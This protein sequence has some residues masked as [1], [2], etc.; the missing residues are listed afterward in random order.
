L[1]DAE[2][3]DEIAPHKANA[4]KPFGAL[5]QSGPI[6]K[7]RQQLKQTTW[8][9]AVN[10][11]GKKLQAKWLQ[12]LFCRNA[13]GVD[14]AIAGW[15]LACTNA[16]FA[17]VRLAPLGYLFH[18]DSLLYPWRGTSRRWGFFCLKQLRR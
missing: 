1:I 13:K 16:I 5:D 4:S 17:I 14:A 11:F 8:V 12:F 6:D 18:H 7:L 9:E 3:A 10:L 15:W 2:G